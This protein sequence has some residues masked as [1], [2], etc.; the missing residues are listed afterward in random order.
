[1]KEVSIGCSLRGRATSISRER[2]FLPGDDELCCLISPTCHRS[3]TQ[4]IVAGEVLATLHG[5]VF[6]ILVGGKAGAVSPD[7]DRG[8]ACRA[9]ARG[10]SPSSLSLRSSYAGHAAPFGLSVAAPRVARRAKR[11]GPGR[12]R[13]CNQTIMS[14]GILI[15]FADFPAFLF[16]FD[17]VRWALLRLYLVRNWCGPGLPRVSGS[18][19]TSARRDRKSF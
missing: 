18:C 17:R 19:G 16:D 3:V 7:G 15:G 2:D 13:T 8:M 14:D 9:K 4:R 5:V 1:L 6:D 12:T 10:S 11:G